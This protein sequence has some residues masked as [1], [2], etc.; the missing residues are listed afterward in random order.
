MYTNSTRTTSDRANE[1]N[2]QSGRLL[3]LQAQ[4]NF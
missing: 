2:R 4:L 1:L 3:R